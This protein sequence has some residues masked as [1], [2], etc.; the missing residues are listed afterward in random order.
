MAYLLF[1]AASDSDEPYLRPPN[2]GNK[3]KRKA[4]YTLDGR[5]VKKKGRATYTKVGIRYFAVL[6]PQP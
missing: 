3:L 6:E 1:F 2:R 4:Q 5:P